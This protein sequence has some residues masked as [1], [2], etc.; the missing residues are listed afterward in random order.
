M[1]NSNHTTSNVQSIERAL[2]LLET[3][4]Q[5]SSGCSIKQLAELTGLNKST[6]HRILHT[7]LTFGYVRQ[8]P[9]TDNYHLG[10]QILN[11]SNHLMD[12]FD[13]VSIAKPYLKKV[14]N[15]TGLVIQLSIR[16]NTSAVFLDKVE[17]PNQNV[18]MYSKIGRSIPLYCSSNGKALLAW[19]DSEE[20]LRTAN[21]IT[22][23]EFTKYTLSDKTA[24]LQEIHDVQKKGYAVDFF[25]HEIT[26]CCAAAP[27]INSS[28]K[29]VA[30]IGFAGTFLQINAGNLSD[31]IQKIHNTAKNIS[32]QLGS[33]SYP[34]QL[35]PEMILSDA[36]RYNE[37]VQ[38]I[39][40]QFQP[41]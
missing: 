36:N 15:E 12:E 1:T 11:L 40:Q 22:Y 24:F 30:A 9:Q 26:V 41:S 4:A 34:P 5:H 39:I 33:T 19:N 31:Y 27:I 28:G 10:F 32:A 37:R 16:N 2:L 3:L 25:E 18:R 13:I 23:Q 8:N 38:E 20:I 29:T 17:N 35:D 21:S 14:C 6:I 7:L